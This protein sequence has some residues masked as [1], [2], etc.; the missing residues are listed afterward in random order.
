MRLSDV[1]LEAAMAGSYKVPTPQQ[2]H[3]RV[4]PRKRHEIDDEWISGIR[5]WWKGIADKVKDYPGR[6]PKDVKE[7]GTWDEYAKAADDAIEYL[8]S[9]KNAIEQLK[10]DLYWTKGLWSR[11]AFRKVSGMTPAYK[12][13]LKSED[14]KMHDMLV[15]IEKEAD[16]DRKE[17][18]GPVKKTVEEI[19]K[20]EEAIKDAIGAITFY[21]NESHPEGQF[22]F[23]GEPVFYNTFRSVDEYARMLRSIPAK[24]DEGVE[25]ATKA[26]SGRLL[27]SLS[28]LVKAKGD[29][30][31]RYAPSE[32]GT[33][34]GVPVE[35]VVHIGRVNLVFKDIAQDPRKEKMTSQM[36][37][38]GGE[39]KRFD[40]AFLASTKGMSPTHRNKLVSELRKVEALLRRRGLSRLWYGDFIKLPPGSYEAVFKTS[41]KAAAAYSRVLDGVDIYSNDTDADIIIHELGHRYWFKFM[42]HDDRGRFK[43][44][45]GKVKFPSKYG[46]TDDAEEFAEL[47]SGYVG[48]Q[49]S[50]IKLN[51]EQRQRFEQFMGKKRRLESLSD[52]LIG[53][54]REA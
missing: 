54:L 20:A 27:R 48:Q 22:S 2:M 36:R 29:T 4:N 15:K 17:K 41:I 19:E 39:A 7:V 32:H 45:F 43:E 51:R 30:G 6:P 40:R 38:S 12:K 1:L 24:A 5:K 3:R 52:Q 25:E 10:T 14:P 44:W 49:F 50:R 26:I 31:G 28:R 47:F 16:E 33:R 23:S 11:E 34:P 46:G 21:K 35:D 9:V 53:A 18:F 37:V 42:S 13:K 8:T